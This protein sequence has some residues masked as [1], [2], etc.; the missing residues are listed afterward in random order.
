MH[1]Q[2][3]ELVQKG[4]LRPPE[5]RERVVEGLLEPLN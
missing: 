1:D 4:R 3:T 5:E 2:V